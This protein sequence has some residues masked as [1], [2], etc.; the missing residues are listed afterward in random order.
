MT[1][2]DR[3]LW[4]G[5]LGKEWT[6][7]KGEFV[8]NYPQWVKVVGFRGEVHHLNWVS[9]YEALKAATGI[10]SPGEALH[11]LARPLSSLLPDFYRLICPQG[12]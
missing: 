4:V 11:Q 12:I 9:N 7:T 1:V 10:Q 5:G 3:H 2:K 8:N 6:T